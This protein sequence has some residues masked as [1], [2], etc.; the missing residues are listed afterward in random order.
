MSEETKDE[1]E[2]GRQ[3]WNKQEFIGAEA[4]ANIPLVWTWRGESHAF[5]T[6]IDAI[7]TYENRRAWGEIV[8][9]WLK[10]HNLCLV[11]GPE[12]STSDE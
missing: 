5:Y 10:A 2:E 3:Y 1:L 6:M 12:K 9:R 4:A 11:P 7:C 8:H